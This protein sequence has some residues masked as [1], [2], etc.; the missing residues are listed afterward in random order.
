MHFCKSLFI[1]GTFCLLFTYTNAQDSTNTYWNGNN[2]KRL[3]PALIATTG[4]YFLFIKSSG[5]HSDSLK[6]THSNIQT[7]FGMG[8]ALEYKLSQHFALLFSPSVIIVNYDLNYLFAS[9]EW[10]NIGTNGISSTI[11]LP[12]DLE[13]CFKRHK[14]HNEYMLAGAGIKELVNTTFTSDEGYIPL[15]PNN[16]CVE[17]GAGME[18]YLH[19]FKVKIQ[20]KY[21][22][23]LDNMI[24]QPVSVFGETITGVYSSEVLFSIAFMSY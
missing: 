20:G 14:N 18:F 5:A 7:E 19:H 2:G 4:P 6:Y 15:N 21:S 3:R 12:L 24:S 16:H 23:G 1:T 17:A 9:R 22:V 13:F 8:I 10:Y 11:E